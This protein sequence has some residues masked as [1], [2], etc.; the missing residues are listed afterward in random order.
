MI[1]SAPLTGFVGGSCGVGPSCSLPFLRAAEIQS[2]YQSV[3]VHTELSGWDQRCNGRS[4]RKQS[5]GKGQKKAN[6]A[7]LAPSGRRR[8]VKQTGPMAAGLARDVRL[9]ISSCAR[10]RSGS[11]HQCLG[12]YSSRGRSCTTRA[13]QA[14][15]GRDRDRDRD[16]CKACTAR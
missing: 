13:Q 8:P 12:R 4:G 1:V 11:H 15:G 9:H 16:N 14:T 10:R 7:A 2:K 3:G 5:M 6:V